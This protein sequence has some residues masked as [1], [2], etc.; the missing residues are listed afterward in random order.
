MHNS[1]PR[2]LDMIGRS[3]TRWAAALAAALGILASCSVHVGNQATTMPKEKLE[4]AVK[5]K[6]SL[7]TTSNIDSVVCDGGL[8]A[9]VGAAQACTV[10]TGATSRRATVRVAD[11][12]G[13]DIGLSIELIPGK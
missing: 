13:S 3:K 6:L 7:K 5:A 12:R 4:A 9:T 10:V 1:E 2:E 8:E 11:I